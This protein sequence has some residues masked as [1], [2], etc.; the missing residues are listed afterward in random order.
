MDLEGEDDLFGGMQDPG[1]EATFKGQHILENPGIRHEGPSAFWIKTDWEGVGQRTLKAHTNDTVWDLFQRIGEE[2][3][4]DVAFIQKRE[5][6]WNKHNVPLSTR[7]PDLPNIF[8]GLESSL[9]LTG[10]LRG[11]T[12][13]SSTAR[14]KSSTDRNKEDKIKRRRQSNFGTDNTNHYC[15][16]CDFVVRSTLLQHG[17]QVAPK[18]KIWGLCTESKFK[19]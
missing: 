4:V 5:A 7:I 12:G 9:R 14:A 13:T 15:I 1:D 18:G 11:G 10:G 8:E 2:K 3:G 19:P 6:L 16:F 17:L